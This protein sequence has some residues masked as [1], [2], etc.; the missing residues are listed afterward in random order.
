MTPLLLLLLDLPRLL[1][2]EDGGA[3]QVVNPWPEAN[4]LLWV[5]IVV[6][7]ALAWLLLL[8][9]LWDVLEDE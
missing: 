8:G 7:A 2:P 1:G 6:G 3:G 9:V 5:L 4:L